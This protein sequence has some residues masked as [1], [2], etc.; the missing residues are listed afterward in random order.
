MHK[1]NKIVLVGEGRHEEGLADVAVMPGMAIRLQADGGYSPETL[2]PTVAALRGLKIA[3]EAG[4]IGSP[5]LDG[6][7]NGQRGTVDAQYAIGSQI[8]FYI[9]TRG[10][11]LNV[12]VKS[13]ETVAVGDALYVEGSTSGKFRKQ[14]NATLTVG[15]T[16]A[17]T[18]PVAAQLEALEASGG[19]L[20]ADTLLRARVL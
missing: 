6:I 1:L 18:T 4:I 2:D 17:V 13:G 10:D 8:F 19:A 14:A 3:K 20:G 5:Y 11:I 7:T 16:P 12:L 15:T 9:P